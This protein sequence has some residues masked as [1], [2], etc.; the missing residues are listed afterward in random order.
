MDIRFIVTHY[1]KGRFAVKPALKRIKN[2]RRSWWTPAKIAAA[3][4]AVVV[5]TATAAVIVRNNFFVDRPAIDLQET[6]TPAP[7]V[8]IVNVI[9]FEN[10]PLPDVVAKISEVYNVRIIN[11][12]DNADSYTLS[13]HY[14]GTADDLLETINDILGTEMTIDEQ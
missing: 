2:T 10:S 9:D 5:I 6:T 14:E 7:E 13:L 1:R 11:L 12:P 8:A 3:L 4:A